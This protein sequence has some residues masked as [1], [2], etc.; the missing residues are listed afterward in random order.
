VRKIRSVVKKRFVYGAEFR[1]E[2]AS[3]QQISLARHFDASNFDPPLV[4]VCIS[5]PLLFSSPRRHFMTTGDRAVNNS[6]YYV[7][8]VGMLHQILNQ[9]EPL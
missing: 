2:E 7:G 9:S 1:F 4:L 8:C 6:E 3:E 5:K